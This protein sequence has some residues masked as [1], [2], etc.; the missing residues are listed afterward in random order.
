[1]LQRYC[2]CGSGSETLL[3]EVGRYIVPCGKV[4]AAAGSESF[5]A[6]VSRATKETTCGEKSIAGS[7]ARAEPLEAGAQSAATGVSTQM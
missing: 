1:M 6:L 7:G 3:S 4:S 2:S 5:M